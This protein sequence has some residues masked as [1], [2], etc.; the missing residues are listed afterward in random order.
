MLA[1]IPALDSPNF[2]VLQNAEVPRKREMKDPTLVP[3]A[4]TALQL[5]RAAAGFAARCMGTWLSLQVQPC[6]V[7]LSSLVPHSPHHAFLPLQVSEEEQ[8]P[9]QG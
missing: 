6:P 2:Q 7:F 4:Y 9:V 8:A 3:T 1:G 5:D